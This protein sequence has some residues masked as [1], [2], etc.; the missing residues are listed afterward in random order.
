MFSFSIS[1]LFENGWGRWATALG[2]AALVLGAGRLLQRV[3][4][5]RL[6]QMAE[7]TETDLDDAAV[8][9]LQRTRW[10][11]FLALALWSGSQVL[12]LDPWVED[13]LRK[14]LVTASFL[15]VALWGSGLITHLVD[16]YTRRLLE[17]DAVTA[18]T[19]S[20]LGVVGR[21]ILW[22][23]IALLA[24]ENL[25]TGLNLS[26]LIAGLGIGGI[27]VGLAVQSILGDLFA[28]LSIVLDKPFVIGD[29]IVVDNL[30]GTVEHIGLKSTRIRSL[31]GEQIIFGNS[32]LLKCRIRNY[33]RMQ[34][35]RVVFH[36]RVPHQT[37]V[38]K[39]EAI[40][41]ILREIIS[42]QPHARFDRAHFASFGNDALLF[43]V[44]YWVTVPDYNVYMDVQQ[45]I[46]LAIC[47]RFAA[48]GIGFAY[49]TQTVH[50]EP[51]GTRQS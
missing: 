49:P 41:G 2:I 22:I 21:I 17:D 48:E 5:Q 37:P 32:D 39:L 24:L 35:R 15:Q 44:V 46:N 25:F 50:L 33:K 6:R 31:T 43:E 11:F 26:A 34:E 38:E 10:F 51:P 20:A 28:S 47:R 18:T 45:A 1:I 40:P 14:I 4:L 36:L 30:M 27:A 7:R 16:R 19:I 8:D 12:L 23:L 29:F 3:V 9:L 42:A 13:A